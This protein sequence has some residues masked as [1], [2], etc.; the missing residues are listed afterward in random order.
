MSVV[1][2][3][4]GIASFGLQ[5]ADSAF[6]LKQFL[7]DIKNAPEELA[8]IAGKIERQHL[9]LETIKSYT[10]RNVTPVDPAISQRCIA[11]CDKLSAD[12]KVAVEEIK[13]KKTRNG[14]WRDGIKFILKK[15]TLKRLENR[16]DSGVSLLQ[17]AQSSFNTFVSCPI[18][19]CF[20][21]GVTYIHNTGCIPNN[22][23]DKNY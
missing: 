6:K 5:V 21:F 14:K 2:A 22:N 10:L 19:Y 13:G 1:S 12:L 16:L 8:Y 9:L 3:G 18:F 11:Y 17:Q 7:D 15:D 4:M 23:I 20:I